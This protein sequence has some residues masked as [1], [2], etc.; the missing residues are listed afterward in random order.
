MSQLLLPKVSVRVLDSTDCVHLEELV[1]TESIVAAQLL[2][3]VL[4]VLDDPTT[5]PW[6][7]NDA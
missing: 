5:G 7:G 2:R 6:Q 4:D 3:N 1:A